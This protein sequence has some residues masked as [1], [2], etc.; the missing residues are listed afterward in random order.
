MRSP[1]SGMPFLAVIFRMSLPALSLIWSMVPCWPV[2]R[3]EE[4]YISVRSAANEQALNSGQGCVYLADPRRIPP[5]RLARCSKPFSR[6]SATARALRPPDLQW[7]TISAERIELVEAP[8]QLAERDQTAPG[9]RADRR[10]GRLAHVEDDRRAARRRCAPSARD[11]H[12]AP[13]PRDRV[14]AVAVGGRTRAASVIVG[15]MPQT[16][17][18]GSLRQLQLAKPHLQRVVDEEPADRAARRSR[19]STSALRSPGSSR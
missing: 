11:R 2:I 13:A 19:E 4:S 17:Q 7:T 14:R 1:P 9:S 3:P 12:L 15:R 6:S 18:S 8:R 5:V 16:G 10:F